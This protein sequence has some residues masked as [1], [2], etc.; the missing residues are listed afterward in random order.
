MRSENRETE[1]IR[2]LFSHF[3]SLTSSPLGALADF[4]AADASGADQQPLDPAPDLRPY[5]L[6]IGLPSTLGL[7][8]GVADVV[9]HRGLLTA[10]RAMSHLDL[11]APVL[12]VN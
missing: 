1:A 5:F 4:A 7:V 9:A 11:K 8:V 6:K 3:S 12:C 10:N 2:S